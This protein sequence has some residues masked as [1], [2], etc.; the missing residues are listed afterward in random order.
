MTNKIESW[1]KKTVLILENQ[2]LMR[3]ILRDFLQGIFLRYNFWEAAVG[4]HA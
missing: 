2:A 3:Q 4:A 1:C